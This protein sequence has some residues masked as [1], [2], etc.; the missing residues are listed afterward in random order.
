M[1]QAEEGSYVT[2]AEALQETPIEKMVSACGYCVCG[3]KVDL[4]LADQ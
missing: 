1:L 4:L 2:G 3:P